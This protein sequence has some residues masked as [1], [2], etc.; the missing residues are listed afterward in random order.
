[1]VR[2]VLGCGKGIQRDNDIMVIIL[3][4]NHWLS[5]VVSDQVPCIVRG[6]HTHTYTRTHTVS[7]IISLCLE[8]K[9]IVFN[10]RMPQENSIKKDGTENTG[11][12]KMVNL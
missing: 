8:A 7:D 1:M 2:E 6:V 5:S 3:G 12:R 11:E 10:L 4:S 9:Q